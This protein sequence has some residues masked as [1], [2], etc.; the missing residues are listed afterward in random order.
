MLLVPSEVA[1]L[2]RDEPEIAP[3][4]NRI[5]QYNGRFAG[6]PHSMIQSHLTSRVQCRGFDISV[7]H[8][9]NCSHWFC[10]HCVVA[11]WLHGSVLRPSDCYVSCRPIILLV[12]SEVASL[13]CDEPEIAP[14]VNW[15]EQ[16]TPVVNWIEQ[17]TPVVNLIEQYN[18]HFAG[19][20]HSMIQAYLPCLLDKRF[21]IIECLAVWI[22]SVEMA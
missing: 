9:A 19:V 1:S 18:G 12:L 2:L 17:Y 14:V 5:E 22:T 8:Q 20:T 6:V 13:L 7:P 11:V 4:M 10:G 3:V 21:Y 16:Y 15:I